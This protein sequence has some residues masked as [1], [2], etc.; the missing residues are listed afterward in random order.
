MAHLE[1]KMI[2]RIVN[3]EN[4]RLF[5]KLDDVIAYLQKMKND[6][7]GKTLFLDDHW[8][9]YEDVEYRF[10]YSELETDEE[11][12]SR[13]SSEL[14]REQWEEERKADAQ[15]RVTERL[16]AERRELD[17]KIAAARRVRT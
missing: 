13:V 14:Q 10:F 16:L 8:T 3:A 9:G 15:K 17:R 6:H 1:K 7:P 5:T 11:H 2:E 4:D 12:Q